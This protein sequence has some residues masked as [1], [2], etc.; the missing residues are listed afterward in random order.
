VTRLRTLRAIRQSLPGRGLRWRDSGPSFC[1][2]NGRSLGDG[3][4]GSMATSLLSG[5]KT[6]TPILRTRKQV[7]RRFRRAMPISNLRRG[8]GTYRDQG[9]LWDNVSELTT[10]IR[11][12]LNS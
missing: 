6:S 11:D 1:G 2:S 5:L 7:T 4:N 12:V 8:G 3:R 10:A 9:L